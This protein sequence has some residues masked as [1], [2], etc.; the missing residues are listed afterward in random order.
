MT[1]THLIALVAVL[2]V[3]QAAS[4]A[5]AATL[6]AATYTLLHSFADDGTGYSPDGSLTLSGSTLYGMAHGVF[7]YAAVIFKINSDGTGYA[8][9]HEFGNSVGDETIPSGSLT[10]SGPTLYGMTQDGGSGDR[11]TVFKINTDGT[12]YT[13]LHSFTGGSGDGAP[14]GS[15]TLSGSILYGM[16]WGGGAYETIYGGDGVIF[17]M[18]TDGTGFTILHDF[19]RV[20]GA[21]PSGSLTLSGSTL[22]GMTYYGGEFSNRGTVFKINSDGTRFT[23]LHSFSWPDG[24]YP[25]GDLTLS[26]STLYGMT[27]IGGSGAAGTVFKI[28][29]SGTGYTILHNFGGSDFDGATPS[30]SL[31][32]SGSTLYG[33]TSR[34]GNNFGGTGGGTVFKINS[35][36]TGYTI[37]HDFTGGDGFGPDASPTLS[38]STLYGMTSQGGTNDAGVIFA[39]ALSEQTGQVYKFGSFDGRKN[40]KL[41]L[42]DIHGADV[43]FSLTGGGY[44]ET[45]PNDSNFSNITLHDTAD[46]SI[47]T[48]S[49][50]GNVH[51]SVGSIICNGSLKSINAKTTAINGNI[52]I[53]AS[54]IPKA[55]VTIIFDRARDLVINSQMPIQSISVAEWLGGSINA[56]SVGSI[57]IK[58]DTKRALS[59]D[60]VEVNITLSQIPAVKIPAL[61]SLTVKG[62]IDSSQI[63]SQGNIGTITAGAII[64]SNCFAGVAEGITGLPAAETASFSETATIKSITIKGI[65][66]ELSPYYINSNIAAANILSAS[67][68]YPQSENDGVPFGLSADYI[69][70]LTIKKTDGTT[71]S[72][73]NL[74]KS[75]DSKTIDGVEIRLY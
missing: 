22:Y 10:L 60:L 43:T 63:L 12:G 34:G 9:L 36:G 68:A 57:T 52:S 44:G 14:L 29:S 5:I 23:V 72:L 25:N 7:D 58:G 71:T 3:A 38:G 33:M 51:T 32:L 67:I 28:N 46:K 11:G 4:A 8:I 20:N 54:S 16:T 21:H 40:V 17:K 2:L 55:A 53:G 18:N 56:P 45:D 6:P 65:K 70:K 42:K 66:T 69:K 31:T 47:L 15:L 37:L 41:T 49:T 59:G 75:T 35:D 73:K 39:L 24:Q 62:W 26:G 19:D 48:I 27:L 50:K 64:D 74:G 13:I 30:G 61:G 1:K